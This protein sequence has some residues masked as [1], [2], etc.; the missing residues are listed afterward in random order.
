[1][2]VFVRTCPHLR[3]LTTLEIPNAL[4]NRILFNLCQIQRVSFEYE[5]AN[6]ITSRQTPPHF[7]LRLSLNKIKWE[8][9]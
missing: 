3:L 1:M 9:S 2:P 4:L 5:T 8:I 7:R 6:K